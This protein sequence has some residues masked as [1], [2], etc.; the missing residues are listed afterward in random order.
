MG[1]IGKEAYS[2]ERAE[3]GLFDL[4]EWVIDGVVIRFRLAGRA[5]V[6]VLTVRVHALEACPNNGLS[7]YIAS[8][9]MH[10]TVLR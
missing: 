5:M 6:P 2:G 9:V 1:S 8:R 7:A 10:L 3:G 4:N